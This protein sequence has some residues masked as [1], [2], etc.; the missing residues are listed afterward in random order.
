MFGGRV[1]ALAIAAVVLGVA[2]VGLFVGGYLA[3]RRHDRR[4]AGTYARNLEE[5]DSALETARAED[6]GWDRQ[7]LEQAARRALDDSR[8]GWE[9]E[10]FEIVLVDDRPGVTEDRAHLVAL[11]GD[12]RVRIVLHR[13]EGGHWSAQVVG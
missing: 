2:V 10:R 6:R 8:P 12:E 7:V 5:A 13:H 3:R 1:D 9:P 4:Y 11:T